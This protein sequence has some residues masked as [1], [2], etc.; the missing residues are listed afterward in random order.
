VNISSFVVEMGG[1]FS[2]FGLVRGVVVVVVV[3]LCLL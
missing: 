3:G 1:T 2:R